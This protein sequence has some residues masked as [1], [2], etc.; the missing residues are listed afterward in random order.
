MYFHIK[1]I[2]EI[3]DTNQNVDVLIEAVSEEEV[4]AMLEAQQILILEIKKYEKG[5]TS[6]GKTYWLIRYQDQI[7]EIISPISEVSELCKL[8]FSLGFE[9]RDANTFV[10]PLPEDDVQTIITKFKTQIQK[11][12]V[13]KTQEAA[14]QKQ[15]AKDT[16]ADKGLITLH[17]IVDEVFDDITNLLVKIHEDS[18]TKKV[19]KLETYQETLKKLRMGRNVPKMKTVLTKIFIIMDELRNT[20]LQQVE[21]EK[22]EILPESVVSN[23]DILREYEK[24]RQSKF[25][26][27]LGLKPRKDDRY[28]I[29]LQRIGLFKRFL[30]ADLE[31]KLHKFKSISYHIF[32]RAEFL[33]IVMLIEFGVYLWLNQFWTLRTD[34]YQVFLWLIIIWLAGLIVFVARKLRKPHFLWLIILAWL[35]ICIYYLVRMFLFLNFAL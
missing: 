30:Q 16:F 32:D 34:L 12:I 5:R 19:K 33:F 13:Q 14:E 31:A 15:A 4:R 7:K 1:A 26:K 22:Y 17:K 10:D 11:K 35:S 28:Y 29:F 20:Y 9:V 3:Y 18:D 6:F 25:I 24:F 23:I 21:T 2:K 8:L 27:E